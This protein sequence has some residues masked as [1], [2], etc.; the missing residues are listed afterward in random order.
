MPKK[1]PGKTH[2][3]KS[4]DVKPETKPER[5]LSESM[6]S[7]GSRVRNLITLG[8]IEEAPL[9]ESLQKSLVDTRIE[10]DNL[11]EKV[12]ELESQNIELRIDLLNSDYKSRKTFPAA[13]GY[14]ANNK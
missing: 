11:K 13:D 14:F 5:K 4:N 3:P 2:Q 8:V 9:I 6:A 12:D 7:L 10:L 1:M